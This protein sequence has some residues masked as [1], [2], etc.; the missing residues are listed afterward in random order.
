MKIPET[1]VAD[2]NFKVEV[3]YA[4]IGIAILGTVLDGDC[5][6]EVMNMMLAQPLSLNAR[7]ELRTEIC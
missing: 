6:L 4:S 5:G 2:K 1:A 7:H 3:L